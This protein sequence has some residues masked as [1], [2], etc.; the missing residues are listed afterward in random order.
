M[1]AKVARASEAC[2]KNFASFN[3]MNVTTAVHQLWL[4]ELCDI[5]IEAV[6]PVLATAAKSSQDVLFYT[7]D[8]ALRLIH[9][10]MPFISEELFQRLP[11][12]NNNSS[13]ICIANYPKLEPQHLPQF[14]LDAEQ[15]F[16][17]IFELIKIIRSTVM[18]RKLPP[19]ATKLALKASNESLHMALKRNETALHSL[20]KSV[21]SISLITSE[22]E[23]EFE[24]IKDAIIL[25]PEN[26]KL[27][28]S[29]YII[30]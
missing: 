7:L 18:D 25:L 11:R 22:N 20:A 17:Q 9:P 21:G 29:L 24:E 30:A 27:S 13:S 2:N 5:Y 3:L 23:K 4:Y 16:D 10:I 19:K 12:A 28:C 8:A 6:K 26:D 15:E 1:I 14:I